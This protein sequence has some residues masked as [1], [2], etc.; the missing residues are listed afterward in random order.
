MNKGVRENLQETTRLK[1]VP[2]IFESVHFYKMLKECQQLLRTG[3]RY[4]QLL[5]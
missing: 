1:Y 5:E 2:L 4:V 3:L